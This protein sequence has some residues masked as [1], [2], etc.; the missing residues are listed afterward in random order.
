MN[1]TMGLPRLIEILDG[2]KEISTPQM[3]IYLK[4][5][6]STG[7]DI[8]DLAL[9]IRQ[10]TLNDFVT[11][12]RLNI[13]EFSI[14]ATIDTERLKPHSLTI[15]ALAKAVEKALRTVTVKQT[16]TGLEIRMK[17][18]EDHGLNDLYRI[19]EKSKNVYVAGL[20]DI[21]QVL[22]VKRKDEYIIITA[23]SNLRKILELDFVDTERTTTNDIHEISKVLGIEAARQS[24]INEVLRVTEAQGLNL[25]IRHIML[26]ADTMTAIGAVKGITRYGVISGKT[27]VLARASFETPIPHIMNAALLGE[28]DH[29][30]SVVENVM[31]NQPIPIG[32]GLPGLRAKAP[33]EE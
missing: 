25:D 7:K 18:K 19:K 15:A 20:K 26:V 8:K 9:Q 10:T 6:Y 21:T 30:T 4:K 32:T 33:K 24:I 13:A 5:P 12:F 29:L 16:A 2:R 31:L 14:E 23:G 3:E 27:S 22:P 11:E 28:V 17:K 1:I